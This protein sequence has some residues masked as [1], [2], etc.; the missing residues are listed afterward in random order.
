[1]DQAVKPPVADSSPSAVFL[2]TLFET[3]APVV[4]APGRYEAG[5]ETAAILKA[6]E[7]VWRASLPGGMPAFSLSCAE[8]AAGKLYAACQLAAWR[9][10]DGEMVRRA[11]AGPGP[12]SSKP[13]AIYSADVVFCFLPSVAALAR[14]LAAGD[15][16]VAELLK[17]SAAWPLSGAGMERPVPARAA[18]AVLAHDG[19]RRLYV[20]R[21]IERAAVEEAAGDPR[22]AEEVAAALGLHG[23]TLAPGLFLAPRAGRKSG[24]NQ[25]NRPN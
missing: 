24:E 2:R 5:L 3:G 10:A 9:E 15:A 4:A 25:K 11:F 22:V 12:D 21:I 14:R 16:L 17:L 6:R 8:W 19:L 1:M 18:A 13:E 20:D 7:A 23:E